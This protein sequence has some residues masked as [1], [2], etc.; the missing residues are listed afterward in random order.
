MIIC[1]FFAVCSVAGIAFLVASAC[2]GCRS[3]LPKEMKWKKCKEMVARAKHG[4]HA[5]N[6][7]NLSAISVRHLGDAGAG[8]ANPLCN[9]RAP[10]I[11]LVSAVTKAGDL[12]KSEH[13]NRV[14]KNLGH[15][16]DRRTDLGIQ[17]VVD[18]GSF[19]NAVQLFEVA[20]KNG[21][22]SE[23]YKLA[24]E[25]FR[26]ISAQV[27]SKHKLLVQP[28]GSLAIALLTAKQEQASSRAQQ[29]SNEPPRPFKTNL[30]HANNAN[31]LTKYTAT[32]CSPSQLGAENAPL[33]TVK[34][35][36]VVT[37]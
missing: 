15:E 5:R 14:T 1:S 11:E 30:K 26:G 23:G 22:D 8:F 28:H 6:V 19:A 31:L 24:A 7:S 27:A 20:S 12:M 33:T 37:M 3:W 35:M 29:S 10:G 36:F 17:N 21:H 13:F 18:P 25:A 16:I 2:V 32:T 34:L 4:G 9:Q